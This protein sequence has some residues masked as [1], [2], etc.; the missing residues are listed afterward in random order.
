MSYEYDIFISYHSAEDAETDTMHFWAQKFCEYLSVVMRRLS[1]RELTFMLHDDLR[2]RKTLIGDNVN[3]IFSKT[4]IFIA[5]LSP[6]YAKS[7]SYLKEI[8][9]IYNTIYKNKEAGQRNINRIFKVNKTPLS[10]DQQPACF[11][12]EISYNF[13]EINRYS[14]KARTFE[15][16]DES[17]P[18]EKFWFKLVDLAY[19]ICSSLDMLTS[20]DI[21]LPGNKQF[22]YLAETTFD[23]AENRDEIK[24]ELQHM[25]YGILPLINLPNDAEKMES[26]IKSYLKR[27]VLS[28]H[29]MGAQY[30][31]LIKNSNFSIPDFQNRIV[32][33]FLENKD[34]KSLLH[35]IIWI[36][37]DLKISDQRQTL[38]LNR[39]KR[40]DAFKNSEIIEA[41]VELFK[42]IIRTKSSQLGQSTEEKYDN[43]KVYLICEEE[44][45]QETVKKY[46]EH[47]EQNGLYVLEFASVLKEQNN[48]TQHKKSLI[49]A[50]AVII[51]Q[52]KSTKSWLISKVHDLIKAPGFGKQK[53]FL[54]V[55]IIS[56]ESL[57][58]ELVK[59]LPETEIIQAKDADMSFITNFIE[60]IKVTQYA[61]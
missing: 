22:V 5:I 30:G 2:A 23:Q 3:E 20:D 39:L 24:R 38:Y 9:E 41:P 36:P 40:D 4:A 56:N 11:L 50:D 32:R 60:K 54:S 26:L 46:K 52:G 59:F 61:R 34:E 29:V 12:N 37:S 25:G 19:D 45:E 21:T 7:A 6:E 42:T 57:D 43:L 1:N 15:I 14:K 31:D 8:E 33:S 28:I 17:G 48:V 35:R 44:E 49:D 58:D 10:E 18:E 53:K 13:F 16:S 27:S 51:Y 55:G 47:L